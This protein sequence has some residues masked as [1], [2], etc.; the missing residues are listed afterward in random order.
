[1]NGRSPEPEFKRNCFTSFIMS[2]SI[3]ASTSAIPAADIA[4]HGH[5]TV[6]QYLNL[7]LELK[8]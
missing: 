7:Q 3:G 4:K 5:L 6:E 1:M 8:V 2:S